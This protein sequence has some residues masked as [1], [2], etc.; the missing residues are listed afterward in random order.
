M[1]GLIKNIFK[2]LFNWL[3]QCQKDN[4]DWRIRLDREEFVWVSY[5]TINVYKCD[6]CWKEYC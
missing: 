6:K 5:T 1:K 2:K 4:C 3:W